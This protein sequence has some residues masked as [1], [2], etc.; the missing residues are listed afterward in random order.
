MV[1]KTEVERYCAKIHEGEMNTER[2][3]TIPE[4]KNNGNLIRRLLQIW[5]R[6]KKKK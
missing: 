6:S 5:K 2:R 4:N 1:T 3:S